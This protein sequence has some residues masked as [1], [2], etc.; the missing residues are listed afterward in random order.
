MFILIFRNFKTYHNFSH[1]MLKVIIQAVHFEQMSFLLY[2]FQSL[3]IR[4]RFIFI[5]RSTN[6]NF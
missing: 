4:I 1:F 3:R 5:E 6:S 2:K